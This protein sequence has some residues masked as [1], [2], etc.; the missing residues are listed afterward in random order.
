MKSMLPKSVEAIFL[1]FDGVVVESADVKTQAFYALYQPY[2]KAI[3]EQAKQYHMEH[4]GVSRYKKFDAIHRQFLNKMC[5]PIEAEQLSGL[6]SKIVF[7]QIVEVP[8]VPGVI[9][10]LK[11]MRAENIPV[12]LLSAT[13]HDELCEIANIKEIETYFTKI[14]GSPTTKVESGKKIIQEW[15]FTPDN[16][17]FVGDSSS[18]LRAAETLEVQFV[19]RV[20]AKYATPFGDRPIIRDF[21]ELL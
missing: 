21:T 4:Q 10:F 2:G 17:V 18:D 3:A 12:F 7:Q 15:G 19:G 14:F 1:D 5:S 9:D 8:F 16:I 13:P 20:P 11:K 6:F